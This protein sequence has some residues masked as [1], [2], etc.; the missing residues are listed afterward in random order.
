MMQTTPDPTPAESFPTDP[1]GLPKAGRPS[2]WSW[3]QA[4]P[5]SCKSAQ[6]PNASAR[7]PCGS[8]ATAAAPSRPT[9]KVQ[10]GSEI[11][12]HVTNQGDLDTTVHWRGLRLENRYDGVPHE[13]PGPDPGGRPLHLPHPVPRPG[14]Y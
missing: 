12:V 9:L 3:P 1:S 2:C 13:T 10:Q 7:P 8:W 11:V 5:W 6:W 14:L 4:T